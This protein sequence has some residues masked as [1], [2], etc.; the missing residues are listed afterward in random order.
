MKLKIANLP[1]FLL[2]IIVL[3]GVITGIFLFINKPTL[4]HDDISF[5]TTYVA[6]GDTLWTIAKREIQDNKY[7][8][9]KD[10][11][12]VVQDLK[13]VNGLNDSS[14]SIGQ[15]LLIPAF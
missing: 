15:K 10:V 8:E 14:L 2:S 4:S 11:R 3:L 1:R 7:Y 13:E 9:N 12:Y 6:K 5:E